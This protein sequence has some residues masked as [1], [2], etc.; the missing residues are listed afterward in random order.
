MDLSENGAQ[1]MTSH[2]GRYV[3]AYNGE[4]YNY[5]KIA[6]GLLAEKRVSA[7]R[8]SSDTEVLLEAVE[9]YGVEKAISLCKGM[10][11]MALYDQKEQ[12]LY[13]VRDRIGES[14][15]TMARWEEAL[16]LLRISDALHCWTG[17][18]I[19]STGTCWICILSTVIFRRPIPFIRGSI[20]WKRE[21]Y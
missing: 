21:T 4:I 6:A 8:G 19:P 11:A 9:S 1:P 13:L 3:I 10:F 12:I 16:P 18:I 14:R 5:R 20:N 17:S 15:F 2:S 7:F